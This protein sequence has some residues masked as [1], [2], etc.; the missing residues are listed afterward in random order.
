[1][2]ELERINEYI[3][4][5]ERSEKETLEPCPGKLKVGL[6]LGTAY[7]VLVVLDAEDRPI[8]CE[9]RAASVLRDGVVVDYVGACALCV[10]SKRSWRPVWVS[11]W[12]DAPSPCRPEP[13]AA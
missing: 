4:Q 6:D 9:K 10:S 13:T 7:I 8:A 2:L 5:V 11:L 12:S 3:A 1:M